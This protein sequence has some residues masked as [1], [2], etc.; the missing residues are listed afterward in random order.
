[1]KSIMLLLIGI[2]LICVGC[3][4]TSYV[5]QDNYLAHQGFV[6]LSKGNYSL[7]EANLLVSLDIEPN[8][9]YSLLNLGAVTRIRVELG[10][11]LKCTRS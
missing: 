1:M 5:T 10:R 6:E 7:A 9:P 4:G 3:V 2:A 11:R 8:N